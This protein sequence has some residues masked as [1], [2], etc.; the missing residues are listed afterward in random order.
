MKLLQA[1]VLYAICVGY[2]TAS[3]LDYVGYDGLCSAIDE[4]R[5]DVAVDL[6]KQDETLG[7]KGIEYVIEK[8]DPDLIANFVN[9]T[10]QANASTLEEL[11]K[12]RSNETFEK[13]LEKVNFPQQA[14]VDLTSSYWVGRYPETFLVLFNKIVK[15]EDQEKAVEK[16]I[17]LLAHSSTEISRL[18]NALKGRAFRSERLEDFAIQKSFMAGTE[19]GIVDLL[20]EDISSHAAITPE[21]YAD[22]LI[23]TAYWGRYNSMRIFLLKHADRYDLQTVKE[24]ACYAGLKVEFRDAIEEALKAPAPGGTRTRTYD[25]QTVEK[26]EETFA[27]LGSSGISKDV[28]SIAS[29]F[30][31]LDASTRKEPLAIQNAFMWGVKSG[32]VKHLPEDICGHAAITPELYADALI[33]TAYWWIGNYMRPFLL[34]NADQY[35]LEAVKEKAGYA[36]L[37][38]YFFRNAIEETLKT[39]A[40]GGTRTRTY[41]I[42]S[43]KIAKETFDEITGKEFSGITDIIGSFLTGRPTTRE[44]AKAVRQTIGEVTKTRTPPS[45]KDIGDILGAYVG[46]DEE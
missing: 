5:L 28:F 22:A 33:V 21:L 26:A 15:P 12:K 42:Q 10:N 41:D 7:K 18:L 29:D 8:S 31:A 23:V 16:C 20:P 14:L 6:V 19:S 38:A 4:G 27:D 46:E 2:V 43:A 9:Q 44:R 25:I 1:A 3:H 39:A 45:T 37:S 36:D 11:W 30:V 13:I 24:K 17:E 32:I 40:P 35:D 34:K